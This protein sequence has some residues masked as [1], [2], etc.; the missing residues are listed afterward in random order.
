MRENGSSPLQKGTSPTRGGAETAPPVQ[1]GDFSAIAAAAAAAASA[2]A[3]AV[4]AAAEN[5]EKQDDDDDPPE[6]ALIKQTAQTGIHKKILRTYGHDRSAG[7]LPPQGDA[8]PRR[9][10]LP[11]YDG[12]TL[13]TQFFRAKEIRAE[14]QRITNRKRVDIHHG[15]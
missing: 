9:V 11:S 10:P 3:A 15:F 13:L 8:A 7:P 4:S 12:E 1:A 6:I 14:R 2:A 5:K